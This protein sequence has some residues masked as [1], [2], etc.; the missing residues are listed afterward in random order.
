MRILMLTCQSHGF[1]LA[2]NRVRSFTSTAPKTNRS[3]SSA[4]P[5]PKGLRSFTLTTLLP[6]ALHQSNPLRLVHRA[7]ERP[8]TNEKQRL[9]HRI[10][11]AIVVAS[12]LTAEAVEVLPAKNAMAASAATEVWPRLQ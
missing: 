1:G 10:I 9:G 5:M 7:F 11:A 12:D 3:I 4:A 6:L 8:T 2:W